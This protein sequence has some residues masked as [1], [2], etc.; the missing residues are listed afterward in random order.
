M[1]AHN[2][3][4]IA[5]WVNEWCAFGKGR[6]RWDRI[7]RSSDQRMLKAKS[8]IL[9]PS[10]C[11]TW[12]RHHLDRGTRRFV[13]VGGDG[14][15]NLLA[16]TLLRA[17]SE[18][19]YLGAIG[20]G[21]S[22]DFHKPNLKE[23]SIAGFPCRLDFEGATLADALRV[24]D[25][26]LQQVRYGLV[27]AS[28]G[29]TAN[30]NHYFNNPDG[31]LKGVKSVS[32]Q[33]AIAYA[34]VRTLWSYQP[35]QIQVSHAQEGEKSVRVTNLGIIKN[36]H[37]SGSFKYGDGAEQDSGDFYV[38]LCHELNRVQCLRALAGLLQGSFKTTQKTRKYRS[39]S[40][41][42]RASE[43]FNVEVDGEV[44]RSRDLEVTVEPRRLWLCA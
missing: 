4:V 11:E 13:A 5:V 29:I 28:V 20:T 16:N 34:A 22:N 21:S 18:S 15:V 8:D 10:S 3:E 38:Y 44:M 41:R 24:R 19:C 12:V 9:L 30:A 37:F 42:L 43:P 23:S 27:N 40:L 36:R 2:S 14:T 17:T 6:K 31:I 1:N 7:V 35:P 33:L 39:R 26:L 25:V 32:A